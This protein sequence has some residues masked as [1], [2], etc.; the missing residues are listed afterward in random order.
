MRLFRFVLFLL[1]IHELN[2]QCPITDFSIPATAC[3]NQRIIP[4]NLSTGAVAYEWDFCSGDLENDPTA[5]GIITNAFLVRSRSFRI[6]NSSTGWYGFSID[7]ANNVLLRFDFGLT[8]SSTPS[9]TRSFLPARR[10]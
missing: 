1:C 5:S 8:P 2:A 3:I 6:V 9:V 4:T 7:Q 10:K